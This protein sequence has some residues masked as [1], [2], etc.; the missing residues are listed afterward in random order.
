[1]D[2]PV[3]PRPTS[4]GD[5]PAAG[6]SAT[7]FVEVGGTPADREVAFELVLAFPGREAMAAYALA[8]ADPA[9]ADYRRFLDADEIG[10]AVR[11][12]RRRPRP[13]GRVGQGPRHPGPL[14]RPAAVGD[15][16][17]CTGRNRRAR[18]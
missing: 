3:R 11:A 9:S 13:R 6:A 17:D 8:V 16:G 1:M 18:L 4:A 14:D 2:E 15:G 12:R 5:G 10:A 7:P